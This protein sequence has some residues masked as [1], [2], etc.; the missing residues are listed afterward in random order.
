MAGGIFEF[1]NQYTL[2]PSEVKRFQRVYQGGVL[3]VHLKGPS[4]IKTYKV[5][6]WG[7]ILGVGVASYE[8]YQMARGFKKKSIQ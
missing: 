4:D 6:M 8:F 5:V 3:P 1:M 2:R 7:C